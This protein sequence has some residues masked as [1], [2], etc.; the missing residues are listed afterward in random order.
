MSKDCVDFNQ[1][2]ELH[3]IRR[4]AREFAENEIRPYMMEWDETQFF[5][6]EVLARLGGLGFMGILVP[7]SYGGAGLGYREY[8]AIVEELARVD[9]SIGLSV[10]AHNSLCTQHI[11]DFGTE[12]QRRRFVLPL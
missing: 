6:G 7:E 9:G 5:P 2:A 3:E 8:I 1:T 10:A 12:E 4:V 11:F